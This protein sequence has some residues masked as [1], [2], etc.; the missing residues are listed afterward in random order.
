MVRKPDV[1]K[2]KRLRDQCQ[3]IGQWQYLESHSYAATIRPITRPL[4]D[5]FGLICSGVSQARM[6]Y[7][8]WHFRVWTHLEA[9][10]SYYEGKKE[11]E[12]VMKELAGQVKSCQSLSGRS[13]QSTADDCDM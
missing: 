6:S 12:L 11:Q 8:E 7:D 13:S 10:T 3:I 4:L 9:C 5:N 1:C 2:R